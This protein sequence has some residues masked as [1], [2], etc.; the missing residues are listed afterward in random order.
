MKK[1][2]PILV[3][4]V[5]IAI[6]AFFVVRVQQASVARDEAAKKA[7]SKKGSSRIVS[8]STGQARAGRVRQ[9]VLL[10][11]ALRAKEQVDVT[12]KATGRVEK[13]T[14]Q[15]GD[16]VKQGELIAVLEDDELQQQVKRA[17]AAMRSGAEGEIG[18]GSALEIAGR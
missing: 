2:R 7:A 16:F 8:V 1:L 5:V 6:G 17:Q 18:F 11:G 3:L 14:H 12:A 15:L 10:T 9:E 4:L 13:V